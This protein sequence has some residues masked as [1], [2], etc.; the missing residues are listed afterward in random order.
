[1]ASKLDLAGRKALTALLAIIFPARHEVEYSWTENPPSRVLLVRHDDRIGNLV[2]MK[3][4]LEGIRQIWP[5]AET[6]VLIGPRFAQI[7]QEEPEIDRLWIVQ[8]KRILRNPFLLMRLIREL[9]R[10][11]YDIAIDCSHMHSFSL[12]GAMLTKLSGAPVRVA[13]DRGRADDFCNLLVDP[14]R[15]EHHESEVLLNLLRPFTVELPEAL[16]KLHLSPE[17][18]D[19][20]EKMRAEC[21]VGARGVLLGIHVGGRGAKK[22]PIERYITLIERILELYK[23]QITVICGPGE[24]E[25]ARQIRQ[26]LVERVRVIEDLG[27]RQMMSL[28]AHCDFFISPDTGPMHLAVAFGV[29][30]AALFLED[31]FK[32]Y[33]PLGSGNRIVRVTAD[34]GEDEALA[35]FAELVAMMYHNGTD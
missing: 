27:L 29:P 26:E 22:W 1:M 21:G 31:S 34:S 18:H 30:T 10:F 24:V 6:G 35:A 23:L 2:L 8:K 7:Y 14:L 9:R 17:E 32:R 3:P 33:G 4:L 28:I 12:T 25:E 16:M 20:A 13:Y 11:E 5:D 15:A 19:W